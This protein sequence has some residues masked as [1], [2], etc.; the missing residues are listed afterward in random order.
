M[1]AT[2]LILENVTIPA[3]SIANMVKDHQAFF[4]DGQ[5]MFL[6]DGYHKELGVA[7]RYVVTQANNLLAESLK[8]NWRLCT[9]REIVWLY[10]TS[11]LEEL[12]T[13][14]SGAKIPTDSHVYWSNHRSNSFRAV[15]VFLRDGLIDFETYDP[16]SLDDR[17]NALWI[18]RLPEKNVRA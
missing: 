15:L 2:S 3:I 12:D 11:Q 16:D 17:H 8:G 18:Q 7:G 13:L 5:L 6:G 10:I 1:K 9:A 4:Q 14:Y